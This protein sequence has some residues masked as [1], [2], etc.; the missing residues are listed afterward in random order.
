[1]HCEQRSITD[2]ISEKRLKEVTRKRTMGFPSTGRPPMEALSH[3][4]PCTH[5]T[6][7][8]NTSERRLRHMARGA[9][10]LDVD[11]FSS[12]IPMKWATGNGSRTSIYFVR[13]SGQCLHPC[14]DHAQ[15]CF[16]NNQVQLLQ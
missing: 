7:S 1:M 3:A 9:V 12:K 8:F 2:P 14:L 10:L 11:T 6:E 16:T 5:G 13:F 4:A 15:A